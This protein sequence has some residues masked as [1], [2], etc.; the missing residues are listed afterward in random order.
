MT[1]IARSGARRDRAD[2]T[3]VHAS[4]RRFGQPAARISWRNGYKRGREFEKLTPP[5]RHQLRIA[6][7][8]LRYAANSSARYTM[9][10]HR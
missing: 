1:W 7:K 8:K 2:A 5:E 3:P 4:G 10:A 6:L 9:R